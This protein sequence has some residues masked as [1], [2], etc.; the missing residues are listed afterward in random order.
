MKR[1]SAKLAKFAGVT[2]GAGVLTVGAV[3]AAATWAG[4]D[5]LAVF[6]FLALGASLF[7]VFFLTSTKGGIEPNTES[8]ALPAGAEHPAAATT[9]IGGTNDIGPLVM[10]ALAFYCFGVALGAV[11]AFGAL[12]GI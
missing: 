1:Q 2:G 8:G 7:G 12:V 5:R 4:W 11:V 6:F 10:P 9:W 3:L